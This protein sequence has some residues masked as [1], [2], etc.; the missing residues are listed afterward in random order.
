MAIIDEL[1]SDKYI[2]E[3]DCGNGIS[4]F[5]FNR[6]AFYDN[7]W[8]N[9]TIKARGLFLYQDTGVIAMRSYDKFFDF[10]DSRFDSCQLRY[11][12]ANYCNG[13]YPFHA[14]VKYNGY[15]AM[16]SADID[17]NGDIRLL[18][19]SKSS[20][21]NWYAT[22]FRDI[23]TSTLGTN[24]NIDEFCDY[25]W[26]NNVTFVFEVIDPINDPHIIRYHSRH[27][28]LLDVIFNTWEFNYLHYS[29]IRELGDE[30]GFE[31]KKNVDVLNSYNELSDFIFNHK[32]DMTVEGYVLRARVGH[33]FKLHCGPYIYKKGIRGI[34]GQLYSG[35][36]PEEIKNYHE[37]INNDYIEEYLPQIV[38]NMSVEYGRCP[39]FLEIWSEIA[40]MM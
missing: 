37:R 18:T 33:M 6:K 20:M 1:R 2:R 7:A 10:N 40:N 36:V 3:Y 13:D 29:R 30:F 5:N 25:A 35:K 4:S 31:V 28:V 38:K 39:T 24:E 14:Y 22:N 19:A 8:Y 12:R 26:Q 27:I 21:D 32:G 34:I 23:F 9:R 15:L 16:A 17:D 11:I